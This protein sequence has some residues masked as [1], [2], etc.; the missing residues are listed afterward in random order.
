MEKALFKLPYRVCHPFVRVYRMTANRSALVTI[1]K[2]Y[3]ISTVCSTP[4]SRR[5][6]KTDNGSTTMD[7]GPDGDCFLAPRILPDP[8]EGGDYRWPSSCASTYLQ[9]NKQM[10][11]NK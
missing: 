2:S 8:D 4:L 6:S 3:R 9:P 11:T 1:P 10:L 7:S 5:E